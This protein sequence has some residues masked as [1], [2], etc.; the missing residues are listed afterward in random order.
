M[1]CWEYASI[2]WIYS[3]EQKQGEKPKWKQVYSICWPDG[4]SEERLGWTS[5]DS[6]E[7]TTSIIELENELG[8]QGWELISVTVLDSVVLNKQYGWPNVGTPVRKSWVFKRQ[9]AD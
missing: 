8:A 3:T 1:T 5:E 6:S 2:T 9:I 7:D 4:T